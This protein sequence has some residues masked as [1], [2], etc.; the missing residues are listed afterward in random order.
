MRKMIALL[1]PLFAC[2]DRITLLAGASNNE[3]VPGRM[4]TS[5]DGRRWHA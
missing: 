3:D 1:L 5:S 4:R 2:A